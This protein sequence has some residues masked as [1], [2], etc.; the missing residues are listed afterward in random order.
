MLFI[1]TGES[2]NDERIDRLVDCDLCVR[3]VHAIEWEPTLFIR[4]CW[5]RLACLVLEDG[6]RFQSRS[7]LTM[8]NTILDVMC[9]WGSVREFDVVVSWWR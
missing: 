3:R 4:K 2:E 5:F 9:H 7:F 1:V 8:M 6:D